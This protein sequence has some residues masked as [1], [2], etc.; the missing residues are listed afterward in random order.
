MSQVAAELLYS[1]EHE[2]VQVL[3]ETK[4]KVGISDFAQSELGDIVFVDLP[5]PGAD[6]V[7]NQSMGTIESVKAVSNIFSPVSGKI[8]EMNPVLADSPETINSDPYSEGWLAV[9]QLSHPDELKEL[10]SSDQYAGF[11]KE[12]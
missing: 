3:S 10:M 6:V 8:I 12:E 5:E 9:I 11:V 1:K 7:A 2:W 4:V